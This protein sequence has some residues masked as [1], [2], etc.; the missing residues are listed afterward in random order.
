MNITIITTSN[1]KVTASAEKW[2]CGIIAILTDEQKARLL[3]MVSSRIEL[4]GP[5]GHV[6]SVPGIDGQEQFGRIGG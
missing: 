1:E 5:S 3:R 2:L 4:G 6:I